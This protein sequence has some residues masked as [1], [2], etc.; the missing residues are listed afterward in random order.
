MS[1]YY[2]STPIYYVNDKPHIGH[3]YTTI[4]ADVL[5]RFHR[6]AG[7]KT[8]FLTGTDE[9]GLKVQQA[10][11][12]RGVP[13]QTHVDETMPRF[14]QLWDRLGITYDR[15]IRTTEDAH[16][17]VVQGLLQDLHD[18]GE[19]YRAEYDGWYCVGCE[20]YYMEK[21]LI[22]GTCPECGRPVEKISESNYFFK[23]SKYQDWL[24][25]HIQDNPGFIQ[26]DFRRNETLGF[27]RKP[28]QDLCISR[29]K[30][31]LA[32]GIEIPFDKDY[33]T[34]VW[35]DALVNYITGVGYGTD[36]HAFG[37]W[38]PADCHLIG[39]DILTTHTV[40]W[41]IM[42]KAA[43]I[44]VPNMIFA[45]GWWLLGDRK[46]SKSEGNVVDP[47]AM[48][49]RYGNDATRYFLMAEMSLGQDA[50]FTEEAF[51]R[52]YNS[53][54]ANDL[55]NLASRVLNMLTRHCGST[56]PAVTPG[57]PERELEK[58]VSDNLVSSF[59][60]VNGMK[61]DQGVERIITS[62]RAINRFLEQ[63]KPW[64][65]AKNKDQAGLD[66]VLGTAAEALCACAIALHPVM[67]SKMEELLLA[68]GLKA[69][70]GR[71]PSVSGFSR[72]L[73]G[74][75]VCDGLK[76]F[77]RIEVKKDASAKDAAMEN[78]EKALSKSE[79]PP[80]VAVPAPD[81][82]VSMDEFK[83][84]QL[85]TARVLTAEKIEGA[86]KLLR[87]EVLVGEEKRQLVAG[88][89]LH[90]KPEDLVGRDVVIVAN[91][92]PAKIRNI[93]SRGMVLC[94]SSGDALKLLAI[95]GT[96]SS[97]AEVR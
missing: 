64:D 80:V 69:S 6:A 90:Y 48:I 1:K 26:P 68:F 88:I 28:L 40:Y 35:F 82:L 38:W 93:E 92:K 79:K 29:P 14:R 94:A 77:P 89:A 31:R 42:L 20:R 39:K 21:D 96:I 49:D 4:L 5:A 66:A 30:K 11:E 36:E 23:M 17:K 9:H 2:I 91:L 10:A 45:H 37:K 27:L 16:K 70:A 59:Q 83:K 47:M 3:A 74:T 56:I 43:G 33:V 8:F 7:E 44:P 12:K 76:L 87:L 46:M 41:P 18:R 25:R 86:D 51:I 63:R 61:M 34:Y 84:I 85:R 57:E 52:R 72:I 71:F 22:E 53:D 65:L 95:D 62:V 54:L 97:G 55:G 19:I 75:T 67:P 73:P 32:W 15:F 81:G 78:N 13:P 50:S 58:L 60:L 24:I